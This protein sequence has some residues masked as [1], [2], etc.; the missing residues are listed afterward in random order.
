MNHDYWYLSRAAG[1]TAYLLLTASVVLGLCVR[2]RI[3][4]SIVRRNTSFDQ[5]RFTALLGLAFTLFHVYILLGDAYFRYTIVQ[6]SLPFLSPYRPVSVAVGVFVGTGGAVGESG[7][8]RDG[9]GERAGGARGCGGSDEGA[10]RLSRSV[11]R[12]RRA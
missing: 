4:D 1:F 6:L 7:G 3:S 12:R 2:T 8:T 9:G 5:H 11:R 10:A